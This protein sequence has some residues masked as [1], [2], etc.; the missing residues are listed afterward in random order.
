LTYSIYTSILG[1]TMP[2]VSN[3]SISNEFR[4][5]IDKALP[6]IIV[7]L[8]DKSETADFYRNF[9]TS[10]EQ[11]MMG[12]RLV[13]YVLLYKGYPFKQIKEFLGMSFEAIRFHKS[14]WLKMEKGAKNLIKRLAEKL[15]S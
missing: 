15:F 5:K 10:E 7:S 13:L 3:T 2:R 1:T 8:R 6:V 12:K 9:L 4:I 11:I 14:N